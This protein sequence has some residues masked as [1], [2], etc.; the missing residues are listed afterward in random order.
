MVPPPSNLPVTNTLEILES[1]VQGLARAV[2]YE[3]PGGLI[4]RVGIP[5][6]GDRVS[7]VLDAAGRLAVIEIGA[8]S[9]EDVSEISLGGGGPGRR[10]AAIANLK[11]DVLICGAVTRTLADLLGASGVRVVPWISGTVSDVLEGFT[12]DALGEQRFAMPGCGCGRA[13]GR[14]RLGGQGGRQRGTRRR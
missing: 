14:R 4:V 6:W 8:G 11:L 10:A 13:Q 5:I 2:L 12:T 9:G 7:P 3:A 1:G